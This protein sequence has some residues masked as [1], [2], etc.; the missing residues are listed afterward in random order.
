MLREAI[1][2]MLNGQTSAGDRVFPATIPQHVT[3]FPAI[4]Y[5]SIADGIVRSSRGGAVTS[6]SRVQISAIDVT[7]NGA[8]DTMDQVRRLLDGVRNVTV[9][10]VAIQHVLLERGTLQD[11][12]MIDPEDERKTRFGRVADFSFFHSMNTPNQ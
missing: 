6:R 7:Y 9:A 3:Q 4:V 5:Q 2:S 1:F 11:M 8:D 12:P 10:G